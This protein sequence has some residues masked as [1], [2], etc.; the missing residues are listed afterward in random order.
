MNHITC[1]H[2]QLP[3]ENLACFLKWK[4]TLDQALSRYREVCKCEP[5]TVY[6]LPDEYDMSLPK[7]EVVND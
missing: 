5:E 2:D 7:L 6:G 4:Y 3:A 1:T